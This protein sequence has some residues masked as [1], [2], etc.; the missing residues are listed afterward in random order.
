M[1][2]KHESV[3]DPEVLEVGL[4]ATILDEL[5]GEGC[6]KN[7]SIEEACIIKSVVELPAAIGLISASDGVVTVADA[8]SRGLNCINCNGAGC[9]MATATDD[10]D[11]VDA[12]AAYCFCFGGGGA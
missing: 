2:L 6:C 5:L 4:E 8:K 3:E 1:V 11:D 10:N 7:T 9:C 12:A